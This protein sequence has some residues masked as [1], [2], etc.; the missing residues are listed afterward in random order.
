MI[1]LSFFVIPLTVSGFPVIGSMLMIRTRMFSLLAG[2]RQNL[3]ITIF[4]TGSGKKQMR[5]TISVSQNSKKKRKTILRF[6]TRIKPYIVLKTAPG[7]R[8][9]HLV[10]LE[11]S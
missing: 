1:T 6:K 8:I 5:P 11:D 2:L 9:I 4:R 3:A 10:H 7:K